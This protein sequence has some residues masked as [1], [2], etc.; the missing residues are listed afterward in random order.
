MSPTKRASQVTGLQRAIQDAAPAVQTAQ[1]RPAPTHRVA[2]NLPPELYRQLQRWADDAAEQL[3]RPRVGVQDAL[4]AM[5]RASLINS[6]ARAAA[7]AELEN[8]PR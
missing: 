6:S 8:E 7:L 2:L 4:R 5:I 3:D 1:T